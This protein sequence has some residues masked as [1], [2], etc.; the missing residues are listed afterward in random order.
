M[1]DTPVN[2]MNKWPTYLQQVENDSKKPDKPDRI[3]LSGLSGSDCG[4]SDQNLRNTPQIVTDKTDNE[5]RLILD[6]LKERT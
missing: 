4:H 1:A 2:N 6:T 5:I 3:S